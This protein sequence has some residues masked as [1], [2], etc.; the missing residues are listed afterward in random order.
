[1]VY[2]IKDGE[3]RLNFSKV[4]YRY[5]FTDTK[6]ADRVE[7]LIKEPIKKRCYLDIERWYKEVLPK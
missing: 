5:D 6:D 2:E 7:V 4:Y 3:L 1:M